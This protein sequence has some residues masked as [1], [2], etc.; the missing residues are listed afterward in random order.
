MFNSVLGGGQF[1]KEMRADL[2]AIID[3]REAQA[4]QAY[5]ARRKAYEGIVQQRGVDPAMVFSEPMGSGGQQAPAPAG[6]QPTPA[7]AGGGDGDISYTEAR[8]AIQ[9]NPAMRQQIIDL[10]RSHG[11]DTTGL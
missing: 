10:A 2:V 1:T 6:G 9:A 4:R 7:P 3:N 11:L 8:A 5:D